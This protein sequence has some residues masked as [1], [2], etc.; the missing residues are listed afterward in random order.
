MAWL[1]AI[2]GNDF[3]HFNVMELFASLAIIVGAFLTIRKWCR[4]RRKKQKREE[5][6]IKLGIFIQECQDL[7]VKCANEKEPPP[8]KE[9]EDLAKRLDSYIRSNLGVEY[10]ARIQNYAGLPMA[11]NSIS[12]REH[13]N[14]WGQLYM[15][16]ARL[17]Q[18]ITD[19]RD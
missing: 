7:M 18:F 9:I 10:I 2:L 5:I 15:W 11:M 1:L 8:D 12:S 14:R 13:R 4:E 19:F 6:R 17:D 3:W 16:T